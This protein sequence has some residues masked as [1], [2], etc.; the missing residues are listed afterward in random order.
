MRIIVY[1]EAEVLFSYKVNEFVSLL[2]LATSSVSPTSRLDVI[3][4][5]KSDRLKRSTRF[6]ITVLN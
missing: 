6:R 4:W 3:V 1:C 2:N 5:V